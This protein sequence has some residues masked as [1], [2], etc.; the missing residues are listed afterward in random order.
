MPLKAP[1]WCPVRSRGWVRA[2]STDVVTLSLA[3]CRCEASSIWELPVNRRH[4]DSAHRSAN[5][6]NLARKRARNPGALQRLGRADLIRAGSARLRKTLGFPLSLRNVE[7]LLD[8]RGIEISHE[9][10]RCWWHRFGPMFAS[11]IRKRRIADRM[12]VKVIRKS[13]LPVSAHIYR[14]Q[15]AC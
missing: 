7:D 8:E 9:S 13:N 6:G 14:M 1:D 5:D 4:N 10:V 11:E 2:G 12:S 3:H 15:P